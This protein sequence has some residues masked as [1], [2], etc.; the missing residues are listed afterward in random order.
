MN[1]VMPIIFGLGLQHS[2]NSLGLRIGSLRLGIHCS[3][4]SIVGLGDSFDSSLVAKLLV[5]WSKCWRQHRSSSS[6][7]HLY[8]NSLL[9]LRS[10]YCRWFASLWSLRCDAWWRGQFRK[11]RQC[12]PK[13]WPASYPVFNYYSNPLEILAIVVKNTSF[14]RRIGSARFLIR[15]ILLGTPLD[16][17]LALL[18]QPVFL[19][20]A[21][22]MMDIQ[23]QE[24]WGVY[25]AYFTQFSAFCFFHPT[26]RVR[27]EMS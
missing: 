15:Y 27:W 12:S 6:I 2:V 18:Y 25:F 13:W 14:Q 19:G 24:D 5:F 20:I 1:L 16:S 8:Q 10:A 17:P 9:P 7:P 11:A 3:T 4:H 26:A 22:L 21:Y 23:Y